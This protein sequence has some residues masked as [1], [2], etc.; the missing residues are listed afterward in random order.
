MPAVQAIIST[1]GDVARARLL[2]GQRVRR[3]REPATSR[4]ALAARVQPGEVAS[5]P[6]ERWESLYVEAGVEPLLEELLRDP[7]VQL[8]MRADR[9]EPADV[10][11]IVD[12]V[13][14]PVAT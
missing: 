14:R 8:L 5:V 13:R 12:S 7:I 4:S 3:G 6:P 2:A 11:R 9:V 10:R 1:L